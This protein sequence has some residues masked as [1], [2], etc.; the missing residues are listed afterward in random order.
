MEGR[1]A[2]E[3]FERV[4]TRE[5]RALSDWA[6]R[7]LKEPARIAALAPLVAAAAAEGD[8]VAERILTRAANELALMAKTV[9]RALHLDRD[10]LPV[11]LGGG[12]FD[13]DPAQVRRVVSALRSLGVHPDV[14]PA[15][16]ALEGAVAIARALAAD[17][18]DERDW[19]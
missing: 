5:A 3:I 2:R 4:G 6:N 14:Q 9:V 18:F 11:V 7:A 16:R 19:H 13:H 10:A 8:V 17:R 1:L 12:V 15:V